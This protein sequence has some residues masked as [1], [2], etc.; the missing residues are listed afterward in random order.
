VDYGQILDGTFADT[1][2]NGVPDCCDEGVLCSPC[3]ADVNEDGVV[4]GAD[5]SAVLGFWGQAGKPLPAA[6]ITQDGIV[7]GADIA[8]LLG[9]WG[10]CQ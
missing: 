9:S 8:V 5:I 7:N 3:P 2:G 1:N 6:D 4:N 10:P